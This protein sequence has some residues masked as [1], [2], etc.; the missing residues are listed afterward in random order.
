MNSKL[1]FDKLISSDPVM[2]EIQKCNLVGKKN[3]SSLN[4]KLANGSMAIITILV[5]KWYTKIYEISELLLLKFGERL[6]CSK[7]IKH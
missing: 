6:T 1:Q 3:H 5:N 7:D 4:N 2:P